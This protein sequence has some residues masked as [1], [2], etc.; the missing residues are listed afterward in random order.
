MQF[1][2]FI[3][4]TTLK[5]RTY[6]SNWLPTSVYEIDLLSYLKHNLN[7]ILYRTLILKE[8]EGQGNL[9][10]LLSFSFSLYHG[11]QNSHGIFFCGNWLV[12]RDISSLALCHTSDSDKSSISNQSSDFI[13]RAL[14][15]FTPGMFKMFTHLNGHHLLLNSH[16][17]GRKIASSCMN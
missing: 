2:S 6:I 4:K 9:E 3:N 8:E 13:P 12:S 17:R 15:E 16:I 14:S 7:P 11:L 1:F 10:W 5:Y